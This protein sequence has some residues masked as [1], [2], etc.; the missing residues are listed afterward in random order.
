MTNSWT[1]HYFDTVYLRRWGLGAP[2][3][4]THRQID[5]LL[6]DLAIG[7]GE[8]LLDLGCGQGRYSLAFAQRGLAV[9]GVDASPVLLA[10]ARRLASEVGVSVNWVL[11]DM[12]NV[13]CRGL[14]HAAVLFDA[15][16]FFDTEVENEEVI[17][18]LARVVSPRGRIAIAVVNGAR[19]LS[20]F[21]P[22]GREERPGV[23]VTLRREFD[24]VR[25]VVREEVTVD[26]GHSRSVAER[27]QRLYTEAELTD[28]IGRS[29]LILRSL[30][31]DL[32]GSP[33]DP[34]TSGKMVAICQC[35]DEGG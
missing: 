25:R 30:F 35:Q 19:I 6:Q 8:S 11:G 32:T 28:I 5:I 2:S 10:E 17:R 20:A 34:V 22:V 1:A 33:F 4:E 18:E 31:G 12:R 24:P 3:E 16:G 21:E 27:R 9:T 23:V 29:G 26:A 15:F 13:P 14:Y 7:P